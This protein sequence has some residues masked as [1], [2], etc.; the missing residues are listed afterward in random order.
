MPYSAK[1]A[2]P[3]Q[4]TI[5]VSA[6]GL[7]AWCFNKATGLHM[8]LMLV[9]NTQAYQTFILKQ[10]LYAEITELLNVSIQLRH[11]KL[12]L[13]SDIPVDV[14]PNLSNAVSA[15]IIT[16]NF[17]CPSNATHYNDVM[18]GEI[19][20]HITS[21]TIVYSTVYSRADQRKHQSSASLA[22]V[23]LIHRGPVNSPHK[24]PVTRK[25]FPLDDV[26]MSAHYTHIYLTPTVVKSQCCHIIQNKWRY[27]A[28]TTNE[29]HQ[30]IGWGQKLR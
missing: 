10:V 14:I 18:M 8:K 19:A 22:F 21:L 29:H 28:R 23:W 26:I 3:I 7:I 13:A 17:A 11:V 27:R 5:L 16:S 6:V 1:S 20:S 4:L 2:V 25:M 12:N 9:E 15:D 30:Y 24:W